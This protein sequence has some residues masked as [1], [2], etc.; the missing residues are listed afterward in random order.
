MTIADNNAFKSFKYKAKLLGNT[1]PHGADKILKNT[2]IAVPLK[3]LSNFWRS[4]EMLLINCKV[5]LKLK[6]TNHCVL[7][8]MVIIM[9]ILILLTLFLLS[10]HKIIEKKIFGTWTGLFFFKALPDKGLV[11]KAKQAKGGRK[12]KE[13]LTIAFF[14]NIAWKK[15]E[16]PSFYVKEWNVTLF[17]RIKGSIMTS[18]CTLLL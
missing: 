1:E 10:R 18:Q 17:S 12:L 16:G 3:Y 14:V 6:W 8:A 15:V 2:T 4:F 11:E 7:F 9:M 5:E 13:R